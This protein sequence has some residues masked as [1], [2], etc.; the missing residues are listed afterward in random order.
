MVKIYKL[1]LATNIIFI[2]TIYLFLNIFLFLTGTI[3]SH[4]LMAR[5]FLIWIANFN[6]SSVFSYLSHVVLFKLRLLFYRIFSRVLFLVNNSFFSNCNL[7][8]ALFSNL[9]I[10]SYALSIFFARE[11]TFSRLSFIISTSLIKSSYFL[12][13]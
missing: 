9:F 11:I 12:I 1:S 13:S 7:F 5:T 6:I 2:I 3:L 10:N 4:V 8:I